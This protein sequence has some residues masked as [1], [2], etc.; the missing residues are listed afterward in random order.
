MPPFLTVHQIINLFLEESAFARLELE[1]LLL[2]LLKD[3][4]ELQEVFIHGL[5]KHDNI[6]QVD[7]TVGKVQL[8]QGVFHQLLECGGG[9]AEPKWHV[10]TLA[11]PQITYCKGSVL[12]G[13]F[14]H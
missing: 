3:S 10:F 5:V 7:Q 13:G 11:E 9:I 4:P 8:A 2:E 12:L 6:V 14:I 1:V